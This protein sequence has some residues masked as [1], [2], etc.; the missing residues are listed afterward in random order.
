MGIHLSRRDFLKRAAVCSCGLSAW[1]KLS[2]FSP[3]QAFAQGGNGTRLLLINMNGGWDG[4]SLLQPSGGNLYS[5]F[6]SL[7]PTLKTDPS[8]LLSVPGTNF[9]FHPSL[10]TFKSLYDSGQLS[11]VLNVGYEHM[12]RS[13]LDAEVAFAR[14][15]ADRLTPL[16]S[17][18]IDRMGH[19]YQWTSLQA[20]SVSGADPAFAGGSY[21]GIQVQGLSQFQFEW[22]GTQSSGEN[23][24]RRDTLY[25]ASQQWDVDPTKGKQQEVLDSIEIA[26][27]TSDSIRSA[28]QSTTFANA[29][30][31]NQLGRSLRD[32]EVLFSNPS[33]GTEVVYV[34]RTGLDTHSNQSATLTPIL[35]ELNSAFATFR[36]NML[37]KNLWQNTVV[38]IFSEFGRTN[39]ENGSLGTDHGGALP[40]FITGGRAIGQLVGN[41]L[42]ADLTDH[43]WLPSK[44][45][46]VEIYRSIFAALGYDPNRAFEAVASP[47]L[48]T[49]FR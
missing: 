43:G 8:Q 34:R 14:G 20:V 3:S 31:N 33:L 36:D 17:G 22:D 40:V 35:N 11:T 42:P 24:H 46:V 12:T 27:N 44:V 15:V 49:L 23:Y 1:G 48:P 47:R 4:L 9:G 26:S 37:A 7:R 16:S 21:R 19:S 18:F 32:A 30:P 45:N 39:A 28:L 6:S 13:H 25:G 2:F 10:T 38:M 29:Y 41:I 5:T